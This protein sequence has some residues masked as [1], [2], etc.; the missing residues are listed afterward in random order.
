MES[1][2]AITASF[3]QQLHTAAAARGGSISGSGDLD[4]APPPPTPPPAA[5]G[6]EAAV[7]AA[8]GGSSS[9]S[10]DSAAT[11]PAPASA[12]SHVTTLF[13]SSAG[14]V[15]S[16]IDASELRFV[17]SAGAGSFARVSI[18]EYRPG[19]QAAAAAA[20]AAAASA[21]AAAAA[22]LEVGVAGG[23]EPGS[24]P[25]PS[26]PGEG[27]M[28][29]ASG[30]GSRR[31]ARLR[32]ASA[33][34]RGSLDDAA[35]FVRV[36]VKALQPHLGAA[37][38]ASL[39]AEGELLSRLQHPNVVGFVAA[40]DAEPEG[41]GAA[42]PF[43]V[44]Q[45]IDG[46][47]LKDRVCE[48]MTRC[49]KAYGLPSAL[50]WATD[51]ASGLAY[52]HSHDPPIAHRD[53]KLENILL[54][55]VETGPGRGGG[56]GGALSGGSGGNDGSVRSNRSSRSNSSG[57]AIPTA[58]IA[59]FGL[60]K[61]LDPSEADAGGDGAGIEE[62]E[63]K[64]KTRNLD[65]TAMTGSF[66]YMSPETLK[67]ERYDARADIFSLGVLLYELFSGVI[68][69]TIVSRVFLVLLRPSGVTVFS[70]LDFFCEPRFFPFSPFFLNL[71]TFSPSFFLHFL[72]KC[73]R[74]SAPR[75]RRQPPRSTLAR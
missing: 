1:T 20:S 41:G 48:Q 5:E 55:R 53:L 31:G 28:G 44:Q 38:A 34:S 46:G 27:S 32:R 13:R 71:T 75:S 60:A 11:A 26:L 65:P 74:W 29:S 62:F 21:A 17:R 51:V 8:A 30:G 72:S 73:C 54:T 2:A 66:L 23:S 4:R 37:A 9:S 64:R 58:L 70:P 43:I 59:D 16:T 50:A 49:G 45:C 25:S 24:D 36:A 15:R 67:G 39:R 22:A 42:R 56:P 69:S 47:T 33:D 12:P 40:G 7:I 52:L 18:C 10:A 6:A 63:S 3:N 57:A 19:P 14:G 61:P 35:G 68:T